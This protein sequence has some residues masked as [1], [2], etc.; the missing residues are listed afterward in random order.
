[1]AAFSHVSGISWRKG[2]LTGL[3]LTPVSVS[4]VLLVEHARHR[5]VDFTAEL[6]ALAAFILILELLGPIVIQ[7]DLMAA[8]ASASSSRPRLA[9]WNG[10]GVKADFFFMVF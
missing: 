5:G 6:S 1:M 8:A 2:M 4:V 10:I 7:P 9:R 3:A